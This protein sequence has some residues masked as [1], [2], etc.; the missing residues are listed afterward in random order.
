[1]KNKLKIISVIIILLIVSGLFLAGNFTGHVNNNQKPAWTDKM[2]LEYAN[3]LLS[4]G[5][6]ANAAQEFEA[7]IRRGGIDSKDLA[8][9]CNKLG[10]IYMDLKEYEKALASFYKSELLDPNPEYK[11]DL[12]QKI[13]SALESLGLSQ[14]A[15]Y[16]L[17]SRTS[18]KPAVQSNEKIAV[19]IGKREITNDE[20]DMVI[21]RLPEQVRKGLNSNDAKL[22]FIRE[23]V[24]TEV[25]YEKGKK[26]GLD[27][28]I[29][30]R[31]AV[32]DFKKQLVLQ[33]LLGE[34]IRKELKTTPEDI[35][36]YYKANKDKY[37]I[38]AMAKVSF[39]ELSDPAKSEE[40]SVQLRNGKGK[41]IEQWIQKGSTLISQDIGES[42]EAV[43]SIFKQEKGTLVGPLKIKDKLYMFIINEKEPEK[44]RAFEE[45]KDRVEGEY[46]EQKEQQIVQ[47]FLN[48][49]L[50]QQEV[51]I[52]YQPKIE[53]EKA[54]K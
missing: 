24:A 25:L 26:L 52:L 41:R 54:K 22:K 20:I 13:V 29:K 45:V 48:K 28:D 23:Y 43:D 8:S 49:A 47:S 46:R 36:L 27:K 53:N 16:E 5:L 6:Y 30:I 15:Q 51:E 7:Y 18:I 50:E 3:T 33:E 21:N 37:S 42:K 10:N 9:I 14:Q 40:V 35:L 34:E 1:M 12:N 32:E 38:P 11:Q 31:G 4:K 44:E 17:E 2:Q 39:L 19:R